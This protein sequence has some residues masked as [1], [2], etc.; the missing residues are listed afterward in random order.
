[1]LVSRR[2]ALCGLTATACCAAHGVA[3]KSSMPRASVVDV[4]HHFYPEFLIKAWAAAPDESDWTAYKTLF[5]RPPYSEWSAPSALERMDASGIATAVLSLPSGTVSFLRGAAKAGMIRAI[6]EYATQLS[7]KHPGRFGL[8]ALLPM[9]DVNASLSEITYALDTLG[10]TGI[11]LMTSYGHRWLGHPDFSPVLEELNRRKAVV[12]VHPHT[13]VCCTDPVQSNPWGATAMLEFP[14][15]SGRTIFDLVQSGSLLRF[16]D[17]EW[18]FSHLGG[19]IPMLAGRLREVGPGFWTGLEHVAPRGID[20]ELRRLHYDTAASAHAPSM[21]AALA[22]LPEDSLLF[23]TDHPPDGLPAAI[24]NFA[25]LRIPT[26]IKRAIQTD[27]PRR[28]LARLP[29]PSG[30]L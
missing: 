30:V 19:V 8:F 18:I 5:M 16:P 2:T 17:I 22:Y 21:Q 1:M 3:A 4:H 23:G 12:H 14:Y 7:Q 6:N 9:P 29:S 24:Q 13:P 20:H 11:G 27:N 28:I 25:A 10:A 15:D 26:R